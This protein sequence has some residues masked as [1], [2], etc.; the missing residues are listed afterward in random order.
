MR[1]LELVDVAV[2]EG[3]GL[4][5]VAAAADEVHQGVRVVLA[6]ADGLRAHTQTRAC[7]QERGCTKKARVEGRRGGKGLLNGCDAGRG[8]V[9]VLTC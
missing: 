3:R 5:E 8:A 1:R 4:V 9:V 6:L 7:A 2:H